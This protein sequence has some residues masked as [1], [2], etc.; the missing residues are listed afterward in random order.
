MRVKNPEYAIYIKDSKE[1]VIKN[2][3]T[4]PKAQWSDLDTK[5][6]FKLN[7]ASTIS[8]KREDKKMIKFDDLIQV[9]ASHQAIY[10]INKSYE[11]KGDVD[12]R[13]ANC[14]E[15]YAHG[16]DEYIADRYEGYIVTDIYTEKIG[17]IRD[18]I[19]ITIQNPKD[20]DC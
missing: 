13:S 15:I 4:L 18:C 3:I 8:Y 6:P 14:G 5:N 19:Y 11:N 16:Y 12:F 20:F 17:G 10:V 2:H 1:P 7:T 9:I